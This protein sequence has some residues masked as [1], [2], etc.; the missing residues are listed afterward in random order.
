MVPDGKRIVFEA[1]PNPDAYGDI[2]VVDATGG[3]PV[4]LTRNPAGQSG[5]ADPAWS[6]DGRRIVLLDNRVVNGV[7]RTGLATMKPDGSDLHF[8]S[9]KNLEAH[10]ADWQSIR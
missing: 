2:Y 10:Q 6:P 1:Y 5:S 4:N 7:G 8:I 3:S 9:S